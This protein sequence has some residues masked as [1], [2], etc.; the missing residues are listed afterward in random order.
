MLIGVSVGAFKAAVG[1]CCIVG[2]M[3]A[4]TGV[5]SEV[6]SLLACFELGGEE[7]SLRLGI[8]DEDLK[9]CVGI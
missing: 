1:S 2:V 3:I 6:G 9:G 4:F 5:G 7:V 8:R